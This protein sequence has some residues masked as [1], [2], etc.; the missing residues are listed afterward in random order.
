MGAGGLVQVSQFLV[1]PD[2][3]AGG[4]ASAVLISMVPLLVFIWRHPDPACFARCVALAFL[5]RYDALL[6]P[7]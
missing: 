4:A 5:N 7:M 1:L 3:G 2:V 6:L